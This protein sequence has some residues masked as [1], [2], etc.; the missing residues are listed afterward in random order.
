[1]ILKSG[2]VRLFLFGVALPALFTLGIKAGFGGCGLFGDQFEIDPTHRFL[3]FRMNC[4]RSEDMELNQPLRF[5]RGWANK[6]NG[7]I[8]IN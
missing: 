8:N 6:P 4:S 3:R 5:L 7:V 1:M 2:L